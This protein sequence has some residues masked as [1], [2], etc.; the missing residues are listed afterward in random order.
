[1]SKL[2]HGALLA[3]GLLVLT[4]SALAQSNSDTDWDRIVL[5]QKAGT[6]MSS[7]S[8][9][10][11]NTALGQQMV[12]GERMML[13]DTSARARL[14]YYKLDDNGRVVRK[15]EKDYNQQDTYVVDASCHAGAWMRGGHV[16][17]AGTSAAIIAG[18]A[19]A[20]ALIINCNW[21]S[22]RAHNK[23]RKRI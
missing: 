10:Y 14:V 21:P 8:G 22:Y 16:A 20:G 9:D 13:A 6:V 5:E 7:Q 4:P 3:V 15:C 12:V 17:G 18:A 1:M 2:L 19:I 11:A 23:D